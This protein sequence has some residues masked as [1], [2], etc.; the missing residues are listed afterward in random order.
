[1]KKILCLFLLIGASAVAIAQPKHDITSYN[2]TW[3][4]NKSTVFH[5][6]YITG[7]KQGMHHVLNHESDLVKFGS[8]ELAAGVDHFYK[9]FRNRNITVMDALTF[10]GDQ[11][12]GV[13]DEKLNAELLKMRASAASTTAPEE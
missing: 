12:R 10:V 13:P 9:D 7:Y 4:L 3:W 2:G 8:V 5:E 6:A 1:M 11:L